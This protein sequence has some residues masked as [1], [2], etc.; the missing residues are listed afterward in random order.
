MAES[1]YRAPPL[2]ERTR[3]APKELKVVLP[4]TVRVPVREVEARKLLP[5]TVKPVEEAVAK[6]DCPVT[7]KGPETVKAVAEAAV[8]LL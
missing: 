4:V 2:V 6:V 7:N 3:P 8:K 5:V 1:V